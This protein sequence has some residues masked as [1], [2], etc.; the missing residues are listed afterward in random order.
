MFPLE[1]P[2][3]RDAV[4][5]CASLAGMADWH[6]ESQFQREFWLTAS[7]AGGPRRLLAVPAGCGEYSGAGILGLETARLLLGHGRLRW[8]V[9]SR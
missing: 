7:V 2:H 5:A 9:G 4:L 8:N 1:H 3:R 6:K